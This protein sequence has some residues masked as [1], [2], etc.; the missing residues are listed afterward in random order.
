MVEKQLWTDIG[1][2]KDGTFDSVII[3]YI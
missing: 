1:V 2:P 3:N